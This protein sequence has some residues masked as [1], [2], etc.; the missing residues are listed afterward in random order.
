MFGTICR[1]R[2]LCLYNM[3]RSKERRI[4]LLRRLLAQQHFTTLVSVFR[5]DVGILDQSFPH[6][7]LRNYQV[8]RN[9]RK[10]PQKRHR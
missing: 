2:I 9:L 6:R 5:G 8:E 3:L 10:L 7:N 1:F 4:V